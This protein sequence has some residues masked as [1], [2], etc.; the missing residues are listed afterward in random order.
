M[1]NC[2]GGVVGHPHS[3]QDGLA[4]L[5]GEGLVMRL[6]SH[7]TEVHVTL[8]AASI[9]LKKVTSPIGCDPHFVAQCYV[10]NPRT[11]LDIRSTARR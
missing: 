11:G 4:S 10:L 1:L 6:L 2:N 5:S 8:M 3:D 7:V 9:W